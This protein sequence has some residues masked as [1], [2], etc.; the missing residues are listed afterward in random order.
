M[1]FNNRLAI[2]AALVLATFF[3]GCNSNGENSV[4]DSE[5]E[6]NSANSATTDQTNDT[7]L[8][9]TASHQTAN[10]R[11][12][13]SS[14]SQGGE[15][16]D[17][18]KPSTEVKQETEEL[19]ENLQQ[20]QDELDDEVDDYFKAAPLTIELPKTAK[21]FGDDREI[22]LDTENRQVIVGGKICLRTGPL[23]MFA[24]PKGTKEHESVVS[25][26]ATSKMVHAGFL[27]IR[28]EPG[29]PVT[30]DPEY[31]PAF[32]PKVEIEVVWKEGDEIK[33]VRAQDMIRNHKTKKAMQTHWVFGGSQV[34]TYEDGEKVYYGDAGEMICLS[35]FSTATMDLPI[36]SINNN[37]FLLFEA[38]T[39][40]IPEVNTQV[41]LFLRPEENMKDSDDKAKT[42]AGK[43]DKENP[44][45]K[46]PET[47]D[48][49]SN[50]K[51][52]DGAGKSE[53]NSE[54]EKESDKQLT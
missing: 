53:S 1:K 13:D 54:K 38:F 29:S 22:W 47:I 3:V 39:E 18:D 36:E 44:T 45:A 30:W 9:S 33:R 23:E 12:L 31:K 42:D 15:G 5:N 48:E 50:E 6:S 10:N 52:N 27:A 11:Q 17:S 21:K 46:P 24:C 41:Y 32:G 49:K 20:K 19:V 51:S 34:Y 2:W 14:P 4:A 43:K 25:V 16:S 28:S 40:N 8:D 35:N 7:G 37:D 26:N